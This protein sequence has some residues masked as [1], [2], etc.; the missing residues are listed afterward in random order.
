MFCEVLSLFTRTSVRPA[1][2]HRMFPS[3]FGWT[4]EEFLVTSCEFF[5]NSKL[6]TLAR[7][8]NGEDAFD[9][10]ARWSRQGAGWRGH[11]AFGAGRYQDLRYEDGTAY[12]GPGQ[13]VLRGSQGAAVLQLADRV[14]DIGPDHCDS[15]RG[16]KCNPEKPGADGR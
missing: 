12:P 10:Q 6:K 13:D 11:K 14:H 8:G 3:D 9:N 16:G 1:H 4:S 5:S 7:G 15:T 2:S